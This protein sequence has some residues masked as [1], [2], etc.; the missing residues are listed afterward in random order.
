MFLLAIVQQ[1]VRVTPVILMSVVSFLLARSSA[2]SR[3]LN[4]KE[5]GP[6]VAEHFQ[7]SNKQIK[8][9]IGIS[10]EHFN[11]NFLSIDLEIRFNM[12]IYV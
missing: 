2:T 9:I 8:V 7:L 12:Q 1:S 6:E 4:Q 3:H 5:L 10:I 11:D